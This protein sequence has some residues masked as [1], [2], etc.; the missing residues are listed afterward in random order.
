MSNSRN[1]RASTSVFV[2][3]SNYSAP[4]LAVGNVA[5][6]YN[7]NENVV[8][9]GYIT[10]ILP[11]SARWSS[12]D[13]STKTMSTIALT[14]LSRTVPSG[15]T[16]FQLSIQ[17][18]SLS[19]GV[20]YSFQLQA[21]YSGQ[22]LYST[23]SMTIQMNNPPVGGQLAVTPAIGVAFNTSF[24]F[25]TYSWRDDVS[26]LPLRYIFSYF[27]LDPLLELNIIK[28]LDLLPTLKTFLGQGL[29][30]MEFTVTCVAVA[31][32]TFD[33]RA[34]V[35]SSVTVHPFKISANLISSMNSALDQAL[36]Q[37]NI[38]GITKVV[39]SALGSLN[40]VDCTVSSPCSKL[41]RREC[42]ATAQT[43][44]PL[45]CWFHWYLW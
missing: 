44:G 33:G 37:Q 29:S 18:F 1:V 20:T 19:G 36:A 3:V 12:T 30:S 24:S 2:T 25:T 40:S 11:C 32:D 5:A 38:Y 22:N 43:C 23:V 13:I 4:R 28:S 17:A 14:S 7:P 21:A 26:D 9:S 8:L 34:N 45:Q 10:S 35:S 41:N 42:M 39:N 6:K 27:V 15:S 31:V 16:I